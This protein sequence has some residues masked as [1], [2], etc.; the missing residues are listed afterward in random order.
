MSIF[1]GFI[2][3]HLGVI[4]SGATALVALVVAW[5]HGKSTGKQQATDAAKAAIG[6]AQSQAVTAQQHAAQSAADAEE[7]QKSLDAVKVAQQAQSDAHSMTS[8]ELD[9]EAARLGILRKD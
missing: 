5:L 3:A 2:V 4:A 9:A 6:A 1:I 8:D 7:A